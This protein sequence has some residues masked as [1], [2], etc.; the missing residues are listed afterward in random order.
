MRCIDE[1]ERHSD[2]HNT[3]DHAHELQHDL[4]VGVHTVAELQVGILLDAQVGLGNRH[5]QLAPQRALQPKQERFLSSLEKTAADVSQEWPCF[6]DG[7]FLQFAVLLDQLDG[8]V[9][10]LGVQ[11]LLLLFLGN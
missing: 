9:D 11:K 8:V 3:A 2:D 5:V 6:V 10:L 7:Y 4:E 1:H